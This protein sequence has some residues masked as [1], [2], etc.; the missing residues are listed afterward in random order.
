MATLKKPTTLCSDDEVQTFL[1]LLCCV[2]RF[3]HVMFRP[4]GPPFSDDHS[5]SIVMEDNPKHRVEPN[6]VGTSGKAPNCLFGVFFGFH[7]VIR[8]Y[9]VLLR[10][11]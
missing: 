9:K 6:C 3:S 4:L 11:L 10:N 2:N 7:G 5:Y 1:C 8:C